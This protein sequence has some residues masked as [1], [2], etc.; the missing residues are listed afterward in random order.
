MSLSLAENIIV[1]GADNHPP[2][3]DKTSYSSWV[4]HMLLY[5]KGKEHGKLLVDSILNGTFQYRTIVEPRNETTLEKVRAR[6]YNDLTYEEKI[7]ESVDIKATNIVL[8]ERDSRLAVPSF[9]PSDDPIANLNKLMAFVSIAFGP[10]FPQ[11]N[12]QLRTSSNLRNQATIQDGRVTVQTIQ[13]R[14]T[15]GYANTGAW[16]NATNEDVN[17]QG[18]AVQPR[19]VKCYSCQEEGHFARQCTKPKR[20]KNLVWFKEKML[21]TEALESGAYLVPKQLAFLADNE[22]TVFPAQASKEIQTPAAFQT[23]DLDAFD[24]DCDDVPSAKAVLMVS[25]SSYDSDVLSE[26]PFHDTNIEND[27]SYQSVQETQSSEQP[28]VDNDTEIDMT[29]GSNIISY[30]Q[31]LQETKNLVVQNTNS[32]TQQYELLMSVIEEMSSQVAKCNEVQQEKLIVHETLTAELERYKEQNKNKALDNVVYKMARRKVP[33]LYDGQTIVKTHDA[34][35]VTDTEQTL[36]LAKECRTGILVTYFTTRSEKPP[37][38]S[39]PVLKN[40]IPHELPS[41]SLVKDSFHK[42]KEHVYKF[43]ETIN[44]HTKITGNRIGSWGVE[45]IKGAFKKDVKP[46]AQTLKEYFQLFEHGLFKELKEMEVVFNQMETEVAKCSIDKKY[47][48]IE[49]KELSLDND[50]L[51]THI[52]CQDV[53]NTIMH[54]NDYSDNVL[55]ANNNSLEHDNFALELLKHENDHLIELL[56]SQDLWN[57]LKVGRKPLSPLQ[58]AVKDSDVGIA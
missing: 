55:H 44:F 51:L 19:V 26:V 24:S 17:R 1:V 41:I 23:D 46:F 37:I 18:A 8:Q 22:D 48:K 15:P 39:E 11:T 28:F 13:G 21:L 12:Y 14:Q 36:E 34:L 56:V 4:S 2:M 38:P 25:L 3:L 6:K 5:I 42:I 27:M 49:K 7:Y 29:S 52:I 20:P 30:E 43:D 57:S 58:L 50:R 31:Y 40:E 47:F 54:G 45:H 35:H 32:S 53:M 9:N 33:A 16:N 10:R